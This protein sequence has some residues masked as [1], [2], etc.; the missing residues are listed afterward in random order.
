MSKLIPGNQKHLTMQDRIT[1]EKMLKENSA[2][3]EIAKILCKDPTTISK[4]I[5]LHRQYRERGY[6]TSNTCRFSRS[7]KVRNLCENGGRC[8]RA[9]SA[10]RMNKCNRICPDF[11]A[12]DCLL[13]SRAPHVCNGCRKNTNCRLDRYYYRAEYAHREYEAMRRESRVGINATPDEI[14]VMDEVISAGLDNGQSVA[15]IV[16]TN[17]D[18]IGCTEKTVYNYL[19]G[20]YFS[21]DNFSL[22]KKLHY[23][24]RKTC[25]AKEEQRLRALDGRR[26]TDFTAYMAEHDLPVTQMDTV[27]AGE[28]TRKV[29][30][31]MLLVHVTV[32][33]PFLMDECKQDEVVRIFD[34]VE[35]AVTPEAFKKTFP[36]ILTDRGP[37]FLCPD[38]L[39][40][41]IDGGIRTKVFYC[42]PNAPFQKGALEKSHTF[43]RRFFP[44]KS[45]YA[46][47][48]RNTFENMSQEKVTLMANHINSLARDSLNG[49][50]PML[51][52]TAALDPKLIEALGLT[53]IPPDEVSLNPALLK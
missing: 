29:L 3:K 39:E 13:L 53:L 33:L 16:A 19:D 26:Y 12:D 44:K 20:G 25:K 30:L 4:E 10:C 14:A 9:C 28:G 15:H 8:D 31:T 23:K 24:P 35:R 32:L 11:T 48:K 22:P 2:L 51:F 18:V 49:L 21:V 27:H 38:L 5:K 46:D 43:I 42:D 1:I 50:M 52:A 34:E 45:A 6:R 17:K 7:C 40:R 41:S 37:E 36:V 47:G